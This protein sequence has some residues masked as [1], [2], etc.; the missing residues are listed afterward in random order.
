MRHLPTVA[1]AAL[2][3]CRADS[4]QAPAT[5]S[6]PV[7]VVR[8]DE[9]RAA[10]EPRTPEAF[11]LEVR[12]SP[13]LG[14]GPGW[15]TTQYISALAR[16]VAAVHKLSADQRAF[17][18]M[19]LASMVLPAR[20]P[21][22][23]PEALSQL[24]T[25]GDRSIVQAKFVSENVA[26]L[27]QTCGEAGASFLRTGPTGDHSTFTKKLWDLCRFERFGLG[28]YD[29]EVSAFPI[30]AHM[31]FVAMD[32]Q[33]GVLELE[34]SLLREMLGSPPLLDATYSEQRA[35]V[36]KTPLR[37]ER[38][39]PQPFSD[40]EPPAGVERVVYESDGRELM[41]WLSLPSG[42]GPHPALV[43][44]HGGFAFSGADFDATELFRN[45][46][47]AVLAPTLRGENG[48]PGSIEVFLGETDDAAAAIRWIAARPE[49]DSQR[50]YAFGHSVG[51]TIASLV[52]LHDNVPLVHSG[53]AGAMLLDGGVT[54]MGD[55]APFETLD[56]RQTSARALIGHTEE[57]HFPHYAWFASEDEWYE[58]EVAN[59]M[60]GKLAASTI[61]DSDHMT[62]LGPALRAYLQCIED[63]GRCPAQGRGE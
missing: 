31:L 54:G 9:P 30:L 17:G 48:N 23:H 47:Y 28:Q 10:Y 7:D 11:D 60:P 39:S 12:D 27:E 26:L 14:G 43:Y 58:A 40:D 4:A 53:S 44:F 19:R 32:K 16:G 3:A 51:G 45:A 41:A 55:S 59:R 6:Q 38:P 52:T 24:T 57:M 42:K 25:G 18:A 22:V 34:S 63:T 61:R 29:P 15:V 21:Q 20:I 62:Q 8:T 56:R 33:G 49:V 1:L 5:T 35:F 2:I 46:G 37:W 36:A 13:D 50:V